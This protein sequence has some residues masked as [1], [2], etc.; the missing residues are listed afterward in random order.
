MLESERF[1]L[2][3]SRVLEMRTCFVVVVVVLVDGSTMCFSRVVLQFSLSF[4]LLYLLSETA[5]LVTLIMRCETYASYLLFEI[6]HFLLIGVLIVVLSSFLYF[7]LS[8][9]LLLFILLTF[10]TAFQ[11]TSLYFSHDELVN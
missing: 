9:L 4:F 8:I 7:F 6:L 3:S 2:A 11:T 5:R 1:V 10:F